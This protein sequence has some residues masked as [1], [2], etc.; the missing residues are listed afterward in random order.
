M[1]L[2]NSKSIRM[3]SRSRASNHI[4]TNYSFLSTRLW[5]LL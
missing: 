4:L 1:T 3:L 2:K 5:W